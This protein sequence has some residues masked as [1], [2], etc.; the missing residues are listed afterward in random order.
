MTEA[1]RANQTSSGI[2]SPPPEIAKN[3]WVDAAKYKD[4]YARSVN[5]PDGF[6]GEMAERLDWFKKPTKIK[7]T[8]DPNAPHGSVTSA[9][10]SP[11]TADA[12]NSPRLP[13][14]I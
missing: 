11:R 6:W 5:D 12:I 3:A 10:D 4:M 1:A 14:S 9:N 2:F 7:N 13:N 8:S